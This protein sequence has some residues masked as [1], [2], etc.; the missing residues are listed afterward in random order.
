MSSPENQ[1]REHIVKKT[2]FFVCD[3]RPA[4]SSSCSQHQREKPMINVQEAAGDH[5]GVSGVTISQVPNSLGCE[6]GER[7]VYIRRIE[8]RRPIVKTFFI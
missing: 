7:W 6:L 2:F 5:H 4:L 8:L 3:I 1:V